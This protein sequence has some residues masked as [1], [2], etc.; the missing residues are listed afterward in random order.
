MNLAEG[1]ERLRK[2]LLD[3]TPRNRLLNFKHTKKS[4]LRVVNEIP[5]FLFQSLLENTEFSFK[6]LPALSNKDVKRYRDSKGLFADEAQ[7]VPPPEEWAK[8]FQIRTS[9][10]LEQLDKSEWEP[11]HSVGDNRTEAI[12]DKGG[13]VSG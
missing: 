3:L 5:D 6:P 11:A 9:Y 12:L 10:E 4:S 7:K 8:F 1:L 13:A 2:R